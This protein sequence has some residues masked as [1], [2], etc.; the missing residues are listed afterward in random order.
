MHIFK[1]SQILEYT[2][3]NSSLDYVILQKS[4]GN[5]IYFVIE[6][7]GIL[8]LPKSNN[9]LE[10]VEAEASRCNWTCILVGNFRVW[11]CRQ[12]YNDFRHT[13]SSSAGVDSDI[14]GS[15]W[16]K[17][18]ANKT[19]APP[20]K[21]LLLFKSHKVR[22]K[23]SKDS[24]CAMVHSYYTIISFSEK[25][26]FKGN[27]SAECAVLPTSKSVAAMSDDAI[28]NA[29]FDY[30]FVLNANHIALSSCLLL[31]DVRILWLSTRGSCWTSVLIV[32]D[33]VVRF[34]WLCSRPSCSNGVSVARAVVASCRKPSRRLSSSE[35]VSLAR[36]VLVQ[37]RWL[38]SRPSCSSSVSVARAVVACCRRFSI[39]H[40]RS[41]GVSVA[42]DVSVRFHWLCRHSCSND[43][44]VA[45]AVMACCRKPSRRLSRS[46]GV[47]E[48]RAKEVI[49][50]WLSRRF[51]LSEGVSVALYVAARRRRPSR[52]SSRC[53]GVSAALEVEY[54][55]LSV[56]RRIH[57]LSK[58]HLLSG[59]TNAM[60]FWC[61]WKGCFFW[62]QFYKL[63]QNK[64]H[65][66]NVYLV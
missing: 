40:S 11:T 62:G 4:D 21:L 54:R 20:N 41:E 17:L 18:P 35:D 56:L 14:N 51:W 43:I 61:F 47:S 13:F 7:I 6:S 33:V 25:W 58:F 3:F 55:F 19:N 8:P 44:S 27:F 23:A 24:L 32:R 1:I 15:V 59:I 57:A 50:R 16:R 38:C 31:V 10:K 22:S 48:A 34:R 39:R 64:C 9:C 28:A 5:F 63:L 29:I 12:K 52:R 49:F 37:F 66:N 36:G 26:G 30:D 60:H 65:S 2:Q 45:R 53:D 46:D 42:R